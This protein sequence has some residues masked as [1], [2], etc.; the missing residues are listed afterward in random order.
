MYIF[1]SGRIAYVYRLLLY[2]FI[3]K[4]ECCGFRNYRDWNSSKWYKDNINKEVPPSCCKSDAKKPACYQKATFDVTNI[5]TKVS[6][7]HKKP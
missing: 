1:K 6:H 5:F 3:L 4:L 2:I 7:E